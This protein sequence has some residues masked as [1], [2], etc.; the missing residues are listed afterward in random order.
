MANTAGDLYKISL[1]TEGDSVKCLKCKY[2]DT[3]PTCRS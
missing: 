2:F 1:E 3:I